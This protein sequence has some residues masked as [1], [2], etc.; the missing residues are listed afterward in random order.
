M[1]HTIFN[2]KSKMKDLI[3]YDQSLLMVLSRFGFPLGFADKTTLEVCQDAGIDY[4][5]FMSIVNFITHENTKLDVYYPAI[6][7]ELVIDYLQNA[8]YY[9]IKFKLPDIKQKLTNAVTDTSEV[10]FRTLFLS[11]FDEYYQ[12][13]KRHMNYENKTVFPYI[14]KLLKNENVSDYNIEVFQKRHHH[15]DSKLAELKNIIIKYFPSSGNNFLLTEV[16]FD[17]LLCE[18]DLATHNRV[19]DFFLVPAIELMEKN[20]NS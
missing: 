16:L 17:I 11:F 19:E 15:I 3:D 20:Q 14:K 1:K 5:T 4:Y 9:F 7:I 12:E 13:V 10:P 18:K 8:H 2:E 6:K